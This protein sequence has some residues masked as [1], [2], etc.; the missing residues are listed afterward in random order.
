MFLEHDPEATKT[1][2]LK[3]CDFSKQKIGDVLKAKLKRY[4]F[5]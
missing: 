3:P 4:T 5:S 2:S 1:F